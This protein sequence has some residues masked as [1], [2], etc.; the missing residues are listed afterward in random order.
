MDKQTSN[1]L[2]LQLR[3]SGSSSV[4]RCVR[5]DGKH[6][7]LSHCV[8]CNV[9]KEARRQANYRLYVHEATNLFVKNWHNLREI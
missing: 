1:S 3:D 9:Y 7:K 8:H 6:A 2:I 5:C 4:V